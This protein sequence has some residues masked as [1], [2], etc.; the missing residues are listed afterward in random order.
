MEGN[1]GT[2]AFPCSRTVIVNITD[3][4]ISNFDIAHIDIVNINIANIDIATEEMK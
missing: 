4:D 1:S 3:V 2:T